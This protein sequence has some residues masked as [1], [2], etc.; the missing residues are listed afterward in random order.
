MSA[1][2]DRVRVNCGSPTEKELATATISDK[3]DQSVATA[4]APGLGWA[5]A[6]LGY[7]T[8]VKDQQVYDPGTDVDKILD[9]Y[10]TGGVSTFEPYFGIFADDIPYLVSGGDAQMDPYR[11]RSLPLIDE[12]RQKA[13]MSV[14]ST[15]PGWVILG[16]KIYL[17]PPPTVDNQKVYYMYIPKLTAD[18]LGTQYDDLKEL[19]ATARC[20]EVLA[21]RRS[22]TGIADREGFA[23]YS[24]ASGLREMAS[25]FDE[26]FEKEILKRA[27]RG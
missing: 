11:F 4:I 17:D 14:G 26:R 24:G 9:V 6:Q 10:W 16:G 8:T 18:S 7:I 21:A 22:S 12:L 13:Y 1:L 3:L 19:W 23:A 5:V 27:F 20:L 15:A 25:I 2:E